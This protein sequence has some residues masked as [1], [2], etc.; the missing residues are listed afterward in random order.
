MLQKL[1]IEVLFWPILKKV[2]MD[3][4]NDLMSLSENYWL[5]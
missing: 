4:V 2:V 5:T 1:L 3:E